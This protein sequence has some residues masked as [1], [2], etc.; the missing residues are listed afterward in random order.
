MI[1]PMRTPTAFMF[2]TLTRV[3]GQTRTCKFHARKILGTGA[4]EHSTVVS[5]CARART[6]N[7][8]V[9]GECSMA[10]MCIPAW[11]EF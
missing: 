10:A 6:R 4:R 8:S 7:V 3:C 11:G 5:T 2:G 9:C 1:C